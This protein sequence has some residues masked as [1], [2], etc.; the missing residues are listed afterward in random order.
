MNEKQKLEKSKLDIHDRLLK[1]IKMHPQIIKPDMGLLQFVN[2]LNTA[3]TNLFE[4]SEDDIFKIEKMASNID[5]IPQL[6]KPEIGIKV[7][8]EGMLEAG[9]KYF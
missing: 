6:V 2:E 7:F 8:A 5:G 1:L 9:K 3:C 4:S